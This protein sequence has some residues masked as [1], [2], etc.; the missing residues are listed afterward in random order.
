MRKRLTK[1]TEFALEWFKESPRRKFTNEEIKELLPKAYLIKTGKKLQD[2]TRSARELAEAGR[3]QKQPAVK[4]RHY[5]YDPQLEVLP[6]E[7]DDEEKRKILERDN[8]RCVV[9]GK[10]VVDGAKVTVGYAMS[11]RRGG[12]LNT[13][14]GRTLCPLHRWTLETAQVSD[15]AQRNWRKLRK[16]LPEVGAPQAQNFWNELVQLLRKYGIDPSE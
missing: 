1:S 10:G 9:C 16:K 12:K 4:A 5:W 8:F 3:I 2:P 6:E 15:E 7:F 13:E 14:N 11:T